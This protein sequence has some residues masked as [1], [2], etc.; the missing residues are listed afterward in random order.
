MHELVLLGHIDTVAGH[1]PVMH[2]DGELYG[3]GAVDAK[4]P[5]AAFATAAAMS[6]HGP[7]WRIVVVGAVEEEAATSKGA[8]ARRPN[9]HAGHCA[10]RRTDGVAE[11]RA[12]L[13][14]AS[15]GRSD[16]QAAHVPSRRPAGQR[17]R[18]SHR[19][20]ELRHGAT[21]G[22]QPRSG[23][24]LGSGSGHVARVRLIRRRAG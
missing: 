4:G 9:P 8:R 5:L 2:R 12:R 10:H 19:L 15:A 20:L 23:E 21:G 16:C 3:R 17:T 1:P 22:A 13:Q 6:G 24:D 14:G 18:N 7:G 11:D